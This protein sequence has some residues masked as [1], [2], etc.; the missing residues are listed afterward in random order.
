MLEA[1]QKMIKYI[2]K[3][4]T[5][6]SSLL[7]GNSVHVDKMYLDKHMPK[8]MSHLSH[9][10]IDVSSLNELG[11]RWYPDVVRAVRK[12]RTHRALDDIKD[13]I[14]ELKYYRTALFKNVP[15][16]TPLPSHETK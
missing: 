13:S 1:E 6:G 2:S 10:I 4:V 12:P 16:E 7:A 8:F 9:R 15:I 3:H 14:I 5:L 11:K